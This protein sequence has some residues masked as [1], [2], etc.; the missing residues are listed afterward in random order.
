MAAKSAWLRR[1]TVTAATRSSR[2]PCAASLAA[3]VSSTRAVWART[4]PVTT[5]PETSYG[6]VPGR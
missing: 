6:P 3:S 2:E 5:F 1:Y 4:S